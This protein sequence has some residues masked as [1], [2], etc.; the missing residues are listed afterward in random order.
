MID[1]A[2][3]HFTVLSAGPGTV[4]SVHT[5]E[6]RLRGGFDGLE[7]HA[8]SAQRRNGACHAAR[9]QAHCVTDIIS[10]TR[11][12]KQPRA[13]HAVAKCTGA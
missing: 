3:A 10:I 13:T 7:S 12:R 1:G 2:E 4:Q 11:S 8:C 5:D 6:C 9:G